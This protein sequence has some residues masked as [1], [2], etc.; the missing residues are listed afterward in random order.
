MLTSPNKVVSALAVFRQAL[1]LALV[2]LAGLLSPHALANFSNGGFACTSS[3]AT[4]WTAGSSATGSWFG[5]GFNTSG[6]AADLTY[7]SPGSSDERVL[8]QAIPITAAT[9]YQYTLRARFS[10]SSQ[11]M[12]WHVLAVTQGTTLTLTNGGVPKNINQAGVKDLLRVIPPNSNATGNW[13]TYTG[14]FTVSAADAVAYKYIVIALVASRNTG[15]VAQFDDV[16]TDMPAISVNPSAG[17]GAEWYSIG[18]G[19]SSLNQVPWNTPTTTTKE[20]QV[21]WLNTTNARFTPAIPTDYFAVRLK[22]SI[23][24]P[25]TGLW[26][27]S[28]GSDDGS[29]LS[30]NNVLVLNQDYL[31]G[32]TTRSVTVTLAS[33]TYPFE[34]RFFENGGQQGLILSWRGPSMT[35]AEVVPASVFQS[36]NKLKV[37]GW[38]EVSQGE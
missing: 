31:Q 4:T 6:S 16:Y 8:M 38:R 18:K 5:P 15:Q 34:V 1:V 28:L 26:T 32:F 14:S 29:S 19:I 7:I 35:A 27:F 9:T 22:G 36:S 3:Q 2:V 25:A 17:L 13:V 23:A 10:A 37:T 33:G 12:Y 11:A 20:E 30:I 21:N 24:I